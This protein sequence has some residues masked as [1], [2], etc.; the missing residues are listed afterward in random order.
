MRKVAI[1]VEGMTEQEFAIMLVSALVGTHGLHV[2]LGR[3][4]KGK[5]TVVPS[6]PHRDVDFFVLI[7]DCGG[8]E[9]VKTQV[10][11]QYPTLIGAGY[12]AVIG[13]RDVYPLERKDIASIQAQLANGMPRGRVVPQMHLAV[14]EVEAWFLSESSHFCGVHQSLTVPFI[15]GSGF[16][17]VARPGDSWEH[18]AVVLHQIYQLAKKSYLSVQGNKKRNRVLRTLRSLSFDELYVNVRRQLPDFDGFL[19]S[20]EQA[21]F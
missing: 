11:E 5:V 21:L 20:L 2:V 12:T 4:W 18:P 10:R 7:I 9:Q 13:L 15:V 16:D 1:F 8:D 19:E 3:Q 17:I 6:A 14:M